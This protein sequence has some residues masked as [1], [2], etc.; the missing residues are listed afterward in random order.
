MTQKNYELENE[1]LS[2]RI[3]N[4]CNCFEKNKKNIA[5]RKIEMFQFER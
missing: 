3:R 4:T 1:K 2:M 5:I